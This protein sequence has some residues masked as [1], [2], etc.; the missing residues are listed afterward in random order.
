MVLVVGVVS[1]GCRQVRRC[2]WYWMAAG[3][4]VR[5]LDCRLVGLEV[6]TRKLSARAKPEPK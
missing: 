6:R 3:S 2:S 1:T 5:S 4:S